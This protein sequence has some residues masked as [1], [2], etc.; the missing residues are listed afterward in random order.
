MIKFIRPICRLLFL[1]LIFSLAYGT[2]SWA[3]ET[4]SSGNWP[5]E[6]STQKGLIVIYEPQPEKL[7]GN[8]LH[9]RSAVAF[10]TNTSSEP[11]FGVVWFQATLDTD[12]DERTASIKKIKVAR[13]N[14]PNQDDE[15]ATTFSNIVE[16]EMTNI[17]LQISMESLLATLGTA[18]KQQVNTQKINTDPPHII[19]EKQPA[20]LISLDGEPRMKPV[21]NS[22]L[23][24]IINTPFTILLKQKENTYYLFADKGTWYKTQDIKG[25]WEITTKVPSEIE[26]LA[27]EP[28]DTEEIAEEKP[29]EEETSSAPGPDPKVIVVTQPTELI[30][31]NGDPEFTPISGTDLLYMSNTDS[32]VLLQITRQSYYILLAGRWFS[33]KSMDGPWKYVPG[34]KLPPEFSKIPEESEM[35]TVL[36]AV[37]G[38][39]VAKEAAMDAAIPQTATINRKTAALTV[40]FDGDPKFETIIT[41]KMTYAINTA[42]PI[43]HV[44]KE[45]YAC[46]NAVWF[47]SSKATGP[48][49]TAEKV[50]DEIYTIPPECPIYHVTFVRI[51]KVAED[52][53]I[54]GYTAGYTHTYVYNTTIVYGSGYPYRGYCGYYCYPCHS[55]WGFHVRYN[56]WS[57]WG[58]GFSYSSGPFRFTI[59]YGGWYRGGWWGPGQHH[60]YRRGYR[61]GY[62]RGAAAG[63]RAG[64]RHGNRNSPRKN[65]Y[66]SQGNKTR[67]KS[68]SPAMANKARAAGKSRRPNNVYAD[69]NGEVHRKTREGWE[70]KTTDG[71]KSEARNQKPT[72]KPTNKPSNQTTLDRRNSRQQLEKNHTSRQRGIQQSKKFNQTRSGGRRSGGGGGRR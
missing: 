54:M 41:T 7:E 66:N 1:F 58:I 39:D 25:K 11:V 55:T 19:F 10:E 30:S 43:I 40:T 45:Y 49:K 27:P 56:P 9:A 70:K 13:L 68:S 22:D 17:H 69:K 71:W 65:L 14:F 36:Y 57:G 24:R 61:H 50:P 23:M 12:R 60:S 38:T 26:K 47:V 52:E 20:V 3:E 16:K 72:R 33:S 48:W 63:Y 15:K 28:E 67:V 44:K 62:R 31:C 5:Y 18:E 8:I 51:Y 4:N 53:I 37:P 46:D 35:G 29:P 42:T 59:G 6:I 34:D 2:P 64:Y 32:D 21:E